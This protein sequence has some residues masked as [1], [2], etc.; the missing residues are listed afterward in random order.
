MDVEQLPPLRRRRARGGSGER[1]A[2]GR[3][4]REENRLMPSSVVP[5][6]RKTAAGGAADFVPA[7]RWASHLETICSRIAHPGPLSNAARC[8]IRRLSTKT[9]SPRRLRDSLA[10]AS[11]HS[12]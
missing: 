6:F 1:N 4:A 12:H 10:L 8:S 7:Q 3:T 2:E 11:A 9:T 5:T